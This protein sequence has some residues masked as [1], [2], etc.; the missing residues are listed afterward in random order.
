MG[1]LDAP[2]R[3]PFGGLSL[4][5]SARLSHYSTRS[6]ATAGNWD[7]Y[8][9]RLRNQLPEPI[10]ALV[11]AFANHAVAAPLYEGAT[12]N[13]I[14]VAAAVQAYGSSASDESTARVPVTFG[15]SM[16]R[17]VEPKTVAYSDP[18]PFAVAPGEDYWLR[19]GVSTP[20]AAGVYPVSGCVTGGTALFGTNSGEGYK[21][22]QSSTA[23]LYYGGS[24][25]GVGPQLLIYGPEAVYGITR[26]GRIVRGLYVAGDSI[27]FGYTDPGDN[28]GNFGALGRG[29]WVQRA[30]AAIGRPYML[31]AISGE[32]G[33]STTSGW[34]NPYARTCRDRLGL[35]LDRVL[36]TY[37]R[38]DINLRYQAGDTAAQILSYLQAG[39]TALVKATC[40]RGK[41]L[42][43]ATVLPTPG[44]TTGHTT[45]AG[46]LPT[47]SSRADEAARRAYNDWLRDAGAS[48]MVAQMTAYIATLGSTAT[49][50]V[51]DICAPIETNQAGVLAANG[52][53]FLVPPVATVYDSGTATGGTTTRLI[54]STKSWA[55]NA[56]RGRVIW[57]H[58]GA[59]QYA[60]AVV[61]Y[62]DATT[63]YCITAFSGAATPDATSQ[64]RIVDAP[65][66]DAT[67]PAPWGNAVIAAD[68]VIQ[69]KLTAFLA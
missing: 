31:G 63:L 47:S 30:M 12:T 67:H 2:A 49:V 64:Y 61:Q 68:P 19:L 22:A 48:G 10:E 55:T 25:I 29:G 43:I 34:I 33:Y 4:A 51:I 44:S 26:S 53:C 13:A 62:N 28:D 24:T 56:H 1:I 32:S 7:L 66:A 6:I 17:T 16:Q 8:R 57:I 40:G 5:S 9:I 54:D 69:A 27:A 35:H 37:G 15:G 46:A 39:V 18:V 59:G 38:N 23:D 65:T 3:A 36:S 58:A 60:N 52:G 20:V 11:F 50:D 21:L 42:L 45:A 41:S 14:T